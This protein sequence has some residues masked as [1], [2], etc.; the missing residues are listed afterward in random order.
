MQ[1]CTKTHHFKIKKCQNFLGW[2]TPPPQVSPL[3]GAYGASIFAPTALKLNVTPPRKILVT[4]LATVGPLPLAKFH[5]Y[6]GK[7]WGY[8]PQNCQNFEFCPEI[9]TSGATRLQYFYEILIVCTRL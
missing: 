2:E 1:A 4:T 7:M 5:V 8:S 3:L 6:R 9:C